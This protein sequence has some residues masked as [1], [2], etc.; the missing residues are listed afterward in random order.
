MRTAQKHINEVQAFP[1]NTI[2]PDMYTSDDD[3]PPER[4]LYG[5]K[6]VQSQRQV[7]LDVLG[8][9]QKDKE[10]SLLVACIHH[11]MLRDINFPA[12]WKQ[13]QRM[14]DCWVNMFIQATH[15]MW[16]TNVSWALERKDSQHVS[17]VSLR[18]STFW[19]KR[20]VNDPKTEGNFHPNGD[21]RTRLGGVV[22][23]CIVVLVRT[24]A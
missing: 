7:W 18:T 19:E 22:L 9:F 4:A 17:D 6:G 20:R 16:D 5:E 13:S 24:G 8:S 21:W 10:D 12:T 15:K 2:G 3:L 23:P 14:R 11:P 1:D